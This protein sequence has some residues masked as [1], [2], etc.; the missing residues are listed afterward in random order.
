MAKLNFGTVGKRTMKDIER[1]IKYLENLD[2]EI[3]DKVRASYTLKKLSQM[4]KEINSNK[5]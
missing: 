1:E 5:K 2:K 4:C 3:S